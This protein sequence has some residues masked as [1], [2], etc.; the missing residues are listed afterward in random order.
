M[1]EFG[2]LYGGYLAWSDSFLTVAQM[3]RKG[4]QK[5]LPWLY[6]L[7]MI[8]DALIVTPTISETV[9]RYGSSWRL[10]SYVNALAIS[11][12]IGLVANYFW[13]KTTFPESHTYN[14]KTSKTGWEH[15]F[16]F[17]YALSFILMLYFG[18]PRELISPRFIV[19]VSA[20]LTFHIFLGTH[21]VLKIWNPEWFGRKFTLA[22]LVPTGVVGLILTL[23]A[24]IIIAF[25]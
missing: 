8:G 19:G 5:G 16:Y 22:D 11:L 18:T 14:H 13:N 6:H 23:Q 17:A 2:V 9:S 12:V 4:F 21:T 10:E 3:R 20:A 1:S 24:N 25:R 15:I 7:G